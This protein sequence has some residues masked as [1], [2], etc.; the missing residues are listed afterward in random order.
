VMLVITMLTMGSFAYAQQTSPAPSSQT[1]SSP[2]ASGQQPS[3]AAANAKKENGAK[4]SNF[5]MQAAAAGMKEVAAGNLATQKAS[6][7]EVKSFAQ[8]MVTDHTKANDELKSLATTKG[9]T[10]PAEGADQHRDGL[11]RLQK[12]NGA[13][14][15]KAYMDAQVKDHEKAVS[16]FEKESKN[17]KDPELQAFAQKTLPTLQ[18]HL[19]KAKE[20]RGK[21]SSSAKGT[22]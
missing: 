16:L 15:D 8:Q 11:D 12:L 5:V 7:D 17:G 21:V 14:F 18:D 19:Q 6:N 3:S 4:D 10:P 2:T 20:L 9:M 22:K 1:P 13:E